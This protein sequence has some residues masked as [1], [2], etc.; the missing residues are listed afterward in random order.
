MHIENLTDSEVT[1]WSSDGMGDLNNTVVIRPRREPPPPTRARVKT[2]SP[3][4]RKSKGK[5]VKLEWDAMDEDVKPVVTPSTHTAQALKVKIKPESPEDV[6]P[7]IFVRPRCL[8]LLTK[9]TS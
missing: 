4:P 9:S 3:S 2:D 7:V 8:T 6:K 1:D 5:K